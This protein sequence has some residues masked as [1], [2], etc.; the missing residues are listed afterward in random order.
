[1]RKKGNSLRN[2]VR[3]LA[4]IGSLAAFF[5]LLSRQ[6]LTQVIGLVR[7]AGLSVVLILV[8]YFVAL[9]FDSIGWRLL[10]ARLR[11]RPP[12]PRLFAIRLCTEALNV[13]LPAGAVFAETLS[14]LLLRDR[15]GVAMPDAVAATLGKKWIVMRSH[16]LYIALSVLCGG[17][18]L[19]AHSRELIG[20]QGLPWLVF[21]S[22]FVPMGLSLGVGASLTRGSVATRIQHW[23]SKLPGRVGAFFTSRK[24]AF[25][26]TDAQLSVLDDRGPVPKGLTTAF[27]LLAW[28]CES[29]ESWLILRVLGA[30]AAF[31]QVLAF[32][33]GLSLLRNFFFFA[34]AGLFFQDLGYLRCFSALGLTD[35]ASVATAFVVLKRAKELVYVGIGYLA[36]IVMGVS[37]RRASGAVD[38]ETHGRT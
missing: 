17:G 35:A 12:V 24:G 31:V 18:V 28:F 14:P 6:D 13:S 38:G 4:F 32:E 26:Q 5:V 7:K 1:M 23:L 20:T 30:N 11:A 8:P 19:A 37:F 10:F 25:V 9:C 16:G 21:I 2:I 36:W 29:V 3:T 22:A 34:P 15:A 27:F 33:A